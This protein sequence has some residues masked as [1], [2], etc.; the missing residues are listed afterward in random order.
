MTEEEQG[1]V[2]EF[3]NKLPVFSEVWNKYLETE[4]VDDED[5]EYINLYSFAQEFSEFVITLY[6]KNKTDE[7]KVAFYEIEQLANSDS[8]YISNVALV[9]FIEGILMLRQHKGIPL[10]AFDEWLGVSSREFWY[11]MH[12]FFTTRST[13]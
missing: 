13:E 10:E 8:E 12:D 6:Q 5:E 9:G 2:T 7:L 3:K 1:V 11:G 4:I